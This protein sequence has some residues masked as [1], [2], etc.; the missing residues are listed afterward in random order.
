M[1]SIKHLLQ[2]RRERRQASRAT[3]PWA[4]LET[5]AARQG[6]SPA[7]V[8]F[9]RAGRPGPELSVPDIALRPHEA[10]QD[11]DDSVPRPRRR[12][13]PCDIWGR[14]PA[15]RTAAYDT[16]GLAPKSRGAAYD[17]WGR[18]A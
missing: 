10:G 2:A 14:T 7:D 3:L 4:E 8:F 17:T 11:A 5:E 18:P 1:D 16:W 9:D 6:C 12:E 15:Q 13:V